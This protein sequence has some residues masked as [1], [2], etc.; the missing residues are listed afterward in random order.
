[1]CVTF[2]TGLI[3]KPVSFNEAKLIIDGE[4]YIFRQRSLVKMTDVSSSFMSRGRLLVDS[5]GFEF[6]ILVLC[7][8]LRHISNFQFNNDKLL[9]F[10][11]FK[12]KN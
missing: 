5:P 1:M 7:F 10:F 11:V 12:L 3:C 9:Y 6:E 4:I 2:R 8:L